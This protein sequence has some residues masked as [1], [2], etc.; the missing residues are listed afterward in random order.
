[1][2]SENDDK[3][4]IEV[5]YK[6]QK[7]LFTAEELSSMVL[8]K[9]KTIAEQYLMCEVKNAVVTVPAYFNDAQKRAT[10]DDAKFTGLNVLRV[11]ND[12]TAAALTYAGFSSGRSNSMETKYV[13]IFDLGGGIFDVSMVKVR[14]GTKGD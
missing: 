14:S 10:R 13:V 4:V 9:M 1:V 2:V 7:K 8:A 3:P 5:D 11:I 6:G 12:A